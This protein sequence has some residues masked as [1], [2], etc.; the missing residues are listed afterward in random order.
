MIPINYITWN[1]IIAWEPFS[2]KP[3]ILS[4]QFFVGTNL[5]LQIF[6]GTKQIETSI[7]IAT[8][9]GRNQPTLTDIYG[10]QYIG[11]TNPHR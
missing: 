1:T 9:L 2:L 8:N 10:H 3:Q 6:I 5:L 4:L 7:P 11:D